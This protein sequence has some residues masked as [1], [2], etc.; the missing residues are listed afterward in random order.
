VL[1]DWSPPLPGFALYYTD[2]RRVPPKLRALIDFLKDE[3][4]QGAPQTEVVL[5]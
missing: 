4:P 3:A 5:R 1:A 2:R